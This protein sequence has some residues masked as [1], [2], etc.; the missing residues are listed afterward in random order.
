MNAMEVENKV[1]LRL[2]VH[3]I[4]RQL[5]EKCSRTG[6][7]YNYMHLYRIIS[8]LHKCGKALIVTCLILYLHINYIYAFYFPLMKFNINKQCCNSVK[9]KTCEGF[10]YRLCTSPVNIWRGKMVSWL[11]CGEVT[12]KAQTCLPH[13]E[14][15]VYVYAPHCLSQMTC[16]CQ[17]TW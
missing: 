9:W 6:I 2:S 7:Y 16:Y 12:N 1:M 10:I 13:G 14:M 5:V 11:L 17:A 8:T 3:C 4:S 15:C